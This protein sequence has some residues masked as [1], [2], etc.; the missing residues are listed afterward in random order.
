LFGVL[1]INLDTEFRVTLYE[2]FFPERAAGALD[3]L[4]QT[5]LSLAFEFKAIT[6]FS[7]LFGVGLAI[8]FDRLAAN[9]RRTMLLVRRLAVLLGF[10]LAHLLLIWNGDILTEYAIAGLLILPLL[11]VPAWASLF[12][13]AALFC[14]HVFMGHLPLPFS[15]P[16]AAWM[17]RHIAEARAM[18][19]HGSFLD[20]AAF[21]IAEVPN[22]ATLLAFIFPR[23]MALMLFGAWIW[24]TG[25]L[26]HLGK[27][28]RVLLRCSAALIGPGL[29]LS[30]EHYGFTSA[31]RGS[32]AAESLVDGFAPIVLAFGYAAL[33]LGLSQSSAV[34]PVFA[35]FAPVG[36][37]AFT[38]YIVQSIVLTLLFY[39]FGFGLMGR[40]GVAGGLG[41]AALIY[42]AQSWGSAWWLDRH[43]FGPLEWLWRTLMYG[44]P[45]QWQGKAAV[46][47]PATAV[48]LP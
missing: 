39:G 11:F 13:A 41:I 6:L 5:I 34:Q 45:Q 2:Q 17:T 23:T 22:I 37:M 35:W 46:A 27:H 16:D 9:P 40:A 38:N 18:Y 3:R 25:L 47:R 21:R 24:R 7:V 43:R 14:V 1:A 12:A 31:L 8:Q 30:L 19:A 48:P 44:E 10:G 28:S 29:L 4:A 15:F 33:L 32:A 26:R 42:A 20:V 36:R